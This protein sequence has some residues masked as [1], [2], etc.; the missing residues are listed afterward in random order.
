[1]LF[2]SSEKAFFSFSKKKGS[3]NPHLIASKPSDGDYL[4]IKNES[5]E[6]SRLR[7]EYLETLVI[8]V[9]L[10]IECQSILVNPVIRGID[11]LEI[12]INRT[13]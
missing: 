12:F 7:I 11:Y 2:L 3:K 6:H 1:M 10:D 9:I 13:I 8:S 5:S 4:S